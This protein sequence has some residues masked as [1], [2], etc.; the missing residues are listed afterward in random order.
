MIMKLASE[1]FS[2]RLKLSHEKALN[3]HELGITK[4]V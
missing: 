3:F 4:E 1:Q 2:E